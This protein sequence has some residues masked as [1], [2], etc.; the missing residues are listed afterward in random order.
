MP[1][2]AISGAI[3]GAMADS[4][5]PEVANDGT[6]MRGLRFA[7]VLGIV[8]AFVGIWSYILFFYRPSKQIDELTDRT[9]PTAAEEICAA[10]MQRVDDLPIASM[11]ANPKER[12]DTVA[13]ANANLAAMVE[14]L[15][16]AQPTGDDPEAKGAR[17][18]V[19]DW[20][21]H[22]K[23]REVYAKELQAGEDARFLES[24]KGARQLSRAIDAFAQ[25]NKMPSCETPQDV[26]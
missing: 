17:E 9:F 10:T 24:T 11:A 18:W 25:V 20:D 23:D 19:G 1:V 4:P 15:Q 13:T 6:P 14:Q 12:G 8:L 16:R 5:S 7:L 2:R 21:Q 26:G 22:V 3:L